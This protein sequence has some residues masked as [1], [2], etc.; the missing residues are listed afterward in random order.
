MKTVATKHS[1]VI[2]CFDNNHQNYYVK[3]LN[4]LCV[5]IRFEINEAHYLLSIICETAQNFSTWWKIYDKTEMVEHATVML[6]LI[7]IYI[8]FMKNTNENLSALQGKNPF[9]MKL[10]EGKE[11]SMRSSAP[12]LYCEIQ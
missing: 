4:I 3:D 6:N 9:L 5:F 2:L 1:C 12:I 11:D 10:E 8:F 7:V